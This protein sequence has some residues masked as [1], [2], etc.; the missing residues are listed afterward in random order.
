MQYRNRQMA[1]VFVAAGICG[2]A[3]EAKDKK[4]AAAQPHDQITVE[5]HLS[6]T[7]GPVTH[8][9][10]TR[11]QNNTWV[12]AERGSGEVTTVLDVTRPD[13]PR[14]LSDIASGPLVSV[15]G[16]AA[17]FSD[18]GTANTAP[19]APQ[20]IR[21]MDLSDP[22]NP[23]V[24]RQFDGVTAVQKIN[25]GLILLANPEGIWILSEH[26]TPDPDEERRYARKVIYGES[27]Y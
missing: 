10:A 18:S 17:L 23:K 12:Y 15:A 25:G 21:V 22:A 11:H 1:A 20:T 9:I 24:T 27:M 4:T 14:V 8:F 13:H 2:Q 19:A 3:A 5:A 16:T 7:G 6:V 26:L